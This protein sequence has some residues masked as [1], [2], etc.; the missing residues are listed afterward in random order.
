MTILRQM[1]TLHLRG[2]LVNQTMKNLTSKEKENIEQ[3]LN[4]IT[5]HPN[6]TPH[7]NEFAK[8]LSHTIRG[9][10]NDNLKAADQEFQISIFRGIVELLYHRRY[11]YKCNSC[12]S[13]TYVTQRGKPTPINR[14]TDH[15][16]NCNK[17]PVN[18][19]YYPVWLQI[20]VWQA[21]TDYCDRRG[22]LF[23]NAGSYF[24]ILKIEDRRES[25]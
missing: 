11:S 15:C 19:S 4:K 24:L 16:P 9:D 22:A 18:P 3:L 25:E 21:H 14:Q 7:R 1:P 10:Y 2:S 17:A 20:P 23:H 13:S 6:L 12:Q 8:T 5:K